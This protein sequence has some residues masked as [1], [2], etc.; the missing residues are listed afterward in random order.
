MINLNW[1]SFKK[2]VYSP[3]FG[4]TWQICMREEEFLKWE[5]RKCFLLF[6]GGLKGNLGV[7]GARGII[8]DLEGN[9]EN[10]FAWGLGRF[11]NNQVEALALFQ[12]MRI[13]NER[14]YRRLIVIGYLELVIKYVHKI[15][16]TNNSV[17][18]RIFC[19]IKNRV[20]MFEDVEF[21]HVMRTHN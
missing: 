8:V 6:D 17:L 9:E 19:Q 3:P 11:T 18:S 1:F 5:Q 13:V 14:H 20:A 2:L 7:A 4:A 16:D 21:F 10:C 12:G 15:F